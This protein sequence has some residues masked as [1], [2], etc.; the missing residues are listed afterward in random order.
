MQINFVQVNTL[1]LFWRYLIYIWIS[2]IQMSK[3]NTEKFQWMFTIQMSK[4]NNN[5]IQW[6]FT[7]THF[8]T[9]LRLLGALGGNASNPVCRGEVKF[10]F[11]GEVKKMFF[12][13]SGN[14]EWLRR[15]LLC[16]CALLLNHNI[17]I[18]SW[19]NISKMCPSVSHPYLLMIHKSWI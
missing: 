7:R 4:R 3:K 19:T 17:S 12:S 8:S 11:R 9:M 6:I 10:I 13:F 5:K 15:S 16:G 14:I 2:T 1:R 18:Y